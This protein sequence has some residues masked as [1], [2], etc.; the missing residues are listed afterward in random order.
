MQQSVRYSQTFTEGGPASKEVGKVVKGVA[1]VAGT[2]S[3]KGK[4]VAP[5][6]APTSKLYVGDV[7]EVTLGLDIKPSGKYMEEND[8]EKA[9]CKLDADKEGY[10]VA[11]IQGYTGG[12]KFDNSTDTLKE[13]VAFTTSVAEDVAVSLNVAVAETVD[14]KIDLNY[15][16]APA[17]DPLTYAVKKGGKLGASDIQTIYGYTRANYDLIAYIKGQATN[18]AQHLQISQ[19]GMSTQTFDADT[20]IYAFWR[21]KLQSIPATNATDNATIEYEA[22]FVVVDE[23]TKKAEYG[24]DLVFSITPDS[25]YKISGDVKYKIGSSGE[26]K[27]A[28]KQGNNYKISGSE[29]TDTIFIIPDI[30]QE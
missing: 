7:L 30:V 15:T 22:G 14:V 29:I 2:G 1:Y 3:N 18:D 27:T 17:A 28:T 24:Q 9:W 5:S 20:T 4:L 19:S 13:Y 10:T 26:Q 6:P 12:Y 11:T 23:S 16:N 25:G 21:G 8:V